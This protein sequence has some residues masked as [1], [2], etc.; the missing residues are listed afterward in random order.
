MLELKAKIRKAG[1]GLKKLRKEGYLP[2]ILYGHGIE[3]LPLVLDYKNFSKIF[4][5]AGESAI[6]RLIVENKE[7]EEKNVLI[8][9][10]L[11]DPVNSKFL[12]ADLYQVRMD[13]KIKTKVPLS[14][15]GESE[16]VKFL[17]GVLVKNIHELEIEALPVDLPKEIT[18]NINY[19]KTFE[20]RIK[21]QDLAIP[22]KVKV[23][24]KFD[25][26]VAMV[27]PPRSEAELEALKGEVLEDVTKVEVV[28]KEKKEEVAT[29]TE[30]VKAEET[31]TQAQ[32]ARPTSGSKK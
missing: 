19:L 31:K 13:E 7:S 15:E 4:K 12:H 8:Y 25:E 26:I 18:V 28:K 6:V 16:A 3:S 10:V 32:P 23:L 17:G 1:A 9:D 14:F 20:D 30:T 24:A 29:E 27:T 11:N 22:T 21:I 2:A 5:Q